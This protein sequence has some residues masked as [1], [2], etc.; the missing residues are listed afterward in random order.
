[1]TQDEFDFWQR[2]YLAAL[3]GVRV[4]LCGPVVRDAAKTAHEALKHYRTA[5]ATVVNE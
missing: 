4:E 1:M 5:K 3:V 2:A